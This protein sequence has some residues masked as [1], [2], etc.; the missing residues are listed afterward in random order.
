[1]KK[2]KLMRQINVRRPKTE[3]G[4]RD[5]PRNFSDQM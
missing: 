5:M 3:K 1:M 2:S 4:E